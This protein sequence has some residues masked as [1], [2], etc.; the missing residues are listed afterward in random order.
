MNDVVLRQT[1]DDGD[2]WVTD[3][4]VLLDGGLQTSAYLCLFGGNFKDDGSQDST[5]GWWGNALETDPAFEYVSRTQN[6]L[7]GIPATSGNLLRLR[8]AAQDD[9]SL[10]VPGTASSVEVL[11]DLIAP[12]RVRFT[13]RIN[14]EGEPEQFIYFANWGEVA[15]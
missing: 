4:V 6:L 5:Q 3:G 11:V 7:Q 13:I 10:L 12:K 1:N 8:R 2:I 9:L 15:Q 14:A